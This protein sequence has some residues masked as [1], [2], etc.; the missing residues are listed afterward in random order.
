MRFQLETR[1]NAAGVVSQWLEAWLDELGHEMNSVARK[2]QQ[3][4]AGHNYTHQETRTRL[5]IESFA[6]QETE[7]QSARLR[8]SWKKLGQ[9]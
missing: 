9:N 6:R 3:F 2:M 7:E 5:A 4:R 1:A 8:A